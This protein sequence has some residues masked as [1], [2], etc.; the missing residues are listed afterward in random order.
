[1]VEQ[2][3]RREVNPPKKIVMVVSPA[4]AATVVFTVI[5]SVA[6]GT[7]GKF[8]SVP[9]PLAAP[10]CACYNVHLFTIFIN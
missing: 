10:L 5:L 9:L 2:V 4:A 7:A 6:D 8:G 3:R 1:M